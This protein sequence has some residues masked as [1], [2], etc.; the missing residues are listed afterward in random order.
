MSDPLPPQSVIRSKVRRI[1]V[2]FFDRG[3]LKQLL[4]LAVPIMLQGFVTA[5]LNMVGLLMIGQKGDVAVAAVGLAGQLFFLLNLVVFGIASGSA[6]FTA[7]LW[8]KKDIPNIHKVLG[9]SLLMAVLASAAFFILAEVFPSQVLAVYTQDPA[10]IAL[11][12]RY[13]QIYGFSFLFFAITVSYSTILRSIGNVRL[14]LTVSALALSFNTLLAYA[15]IFGKLGLPAMGVTGAAIAAV[16]ARFVECA[17]I[18]AVTY[19]TKSPVAAKLKELLAIELKFAGKVL[20]P[21]LPVALNEFLWAMGITTYNA[22]Y[23]RI[24]TGSIAAMNIISTIE[25]LAFVVFTGICLATAVMVGHHIGGG[26]EKRAFSDAGRSLGLGAASGLLLG[27]MALLGGDKILT[28]YKVSPAVLA[29]AHRVLTIFGLLLWLRAMNSILVVG[30]LRGGGDTRFS[31]FLDGFIIWIVG[32]PLAALGAFVF[33]FPVYWV[34]LL[35]MSEEIIKWC[36]GLLR[37]FSRKWI[38]NLTH[39]LPDTTRT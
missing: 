30:I 20:K 37:F 18:L 6:I 10:V 29:D 14:P 39:T 33:H 36:L 34:Y 15:L 3:Y 7:Q 25:N 13:L 1:A 11:G 35:A 22:I 9:L 17:G 21:V 38:H 12:S 2:T 8:G 19:L 24:G 32:V 27:G 31:L 28:L 16:A 5:S 23:A 26:E 4:K